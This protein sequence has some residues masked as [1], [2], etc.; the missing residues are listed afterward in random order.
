MPQDGFHYCKADL[1]TFNDPELA[2]RRRGAPFTFDVNS[3][4]ELVSSLKKT[5]VATGAESEAFIQA[6]SFDHTRQDPV[7]DDVQISS[8]TQVVVIEG[9]YTLLNEDPWDQIAEAV[10]E[11]QVFL[12]LY[13]ALR[14]H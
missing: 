14:V 6:P 2:F 7:E 11:R 1:A 9:N 3:L 5:P 10:D 13:S 4:L 12:E 8:K